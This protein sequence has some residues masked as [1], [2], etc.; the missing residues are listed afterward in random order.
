MCFTW[1]YINASTWS[2]PDRWKSVNAGCIQ[3]CQKC[4]HKY[5][6][7][8]ASCIHFQMWVRTGLVLHAHI[9]IGNVY[10]WVSCKWFV[11][12]YLTHVF[13]V[14]NVLHYLLHS[15]FTHVLCIIYVWLDNWF[16]INFLCVIYLSIGFVPL[17]MLSNL[18]RKLYTI[19]HVWF[20]C[21][22]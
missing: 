2:C 1:I 12:N 17:F 18:Y 20:L 8:S 13:E 11:P 6:H 15:L 14:P 16:M 9:F 10:S 5:P 22:F 7:M 4:L 19:F 21:R 3:V